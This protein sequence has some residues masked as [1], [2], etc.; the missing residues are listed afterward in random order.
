MPT[1]CLACPLRKKDMFAKL[2]REDV[3]A[4]Q[5]FKAGE[6]QIEPG[7][8]ILLEGSN[9]PQLYTALSGLGLRYKTLPDGR[10]QVINL[11][12]PG[13]FLGLQAGLMGKMRHSVEATTAMTLCV[14]DRAEFFRFFRSHTERAFDITWLAAVEEHFLGEAL[15]SLGQRSATSRMAWALLKIWH[16]MNG[17]GLCDASGRCPL[18]YRQQ[19]LADALGLSLVHTNKTL[20]KLRE[21]QL[22]SWS[23]GMLRLTDLRA[24]T[25]LAGAEFESEIV[26]PLI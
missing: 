1:R 2:G 19:D 9:S 5:R 3:E 20:A 7:T 21:R 22:V 6:M 12:F 15:A 25:D 23:G 16:R 17:L 24:L 4:I 10:R 11:V 13:D 8:A 14:F 18:P 26:R